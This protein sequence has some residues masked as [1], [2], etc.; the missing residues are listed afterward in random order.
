MATTS[1][2]LTKEDRAEQQIMAVDKELNRILVRK[3]R[4]T[5]RDSKSGNGD[6]ENVS[7]KGISVSSSFLK[8]TYS[9]K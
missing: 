9:S 5:N 4:V 3:T 2:A 7:K 8:P 1:K 6:K